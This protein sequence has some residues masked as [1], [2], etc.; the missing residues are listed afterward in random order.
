[1]PI[2]EQ[3]VDAIGRHR[4]QPLSLAFDLVIVLLA[5]E[6][7]DASGQIAD[8]LYRVIFLM[9]RIHQVEQRLAAPL[10]LQGRQMVFHQETEPAMEVVQGK[11]RRG[12]LAGPA[13]DGRQI[14]LLHGPIQFCQT[15]A[16]PIRVVGK[17]NGDKI[18]RPS[19]AGSSGC[20]E[21]PGLFRQ[22]VRQFCRRTIQHG[23]V[24][25]VDLQAAL[26]PSEVLC[27][28]FE[29]GPVKIIQRRQPRS[30]SAVQVAHL[31]GYGVVNVA[32]ANYGDASGSQRIA[33]A[34]ENRPAGTHALLDQ[35]GQFVQIAGAI[36][37][38]GGRSSHRSRSSM[39]V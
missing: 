31:F 18:V 2:V 7:E 5:V 26:V 36:L 20:I 23:F 30:G 35:G 12:Q 11:S 6:T 19:G 4:E 13:L 27:C 3:L 32:G 14:F 33:A 16:R 22:L 34:Q 15:I 10:K 38:R 39:V 17:P 37:P 28:R 1:M 25:Q 8:C 24:F 29:T 21:L 9:L